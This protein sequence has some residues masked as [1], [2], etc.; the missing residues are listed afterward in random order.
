[1]I[2]VKRGS[3]YFCFSLMVVIGNLLWQL[4]GI[5][6]TVLCGV[7]VSGGWPLTIVGGTKYLPLRSV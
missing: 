7:G 6:C 1:M 5:I 3:Y 4:K 2:M